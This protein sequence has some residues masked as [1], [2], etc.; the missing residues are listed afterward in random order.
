MISSRITN[1]AGTAEIEGFGGASSNS[2]VSLFQ[3]KTPRRPFPCLPIS[4]I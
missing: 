3:K 2:P 1:G 4:L